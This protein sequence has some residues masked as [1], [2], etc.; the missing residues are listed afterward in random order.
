MSVRQIFLEQVDEILAKSEET[1]TNLE[2]GGWRT[3]LLRDTYVRSGKTAMYDGS[4]VCFLSH[5]RMFCF[6][7]GALNQEGWVVV[8]KAVM[9]VFSTT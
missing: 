8:K 2:G 4:Q 5:S 1:K 3:Q 7:L 6:F 9:F